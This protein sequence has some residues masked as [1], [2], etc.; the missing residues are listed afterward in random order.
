M[1]YSRLSDVTGCFSDYDPDALP[2]EK[3]QQIVREFVTPID[4]VEKVALRS[5]LGRVLAHDV[6]SPINVPQHDNSA[7]DGYAFS[8]AALGGSQPVTLEVVATV[9]AGASF[10]R[11]VRDDQCVRI[12]TGAPMPPG[13]DTVV[14]QELTRAA[15]SGKVTFAS[16]GARRATTGDCR[17]KT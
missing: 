7:M 4:A 13:C 12:M 5:A 3:A 1:S 16:G 6:V 10:D 14:P 15:A 8:S 9:L 2:V 17:G 11:T